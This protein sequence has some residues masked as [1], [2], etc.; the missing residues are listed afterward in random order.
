MARAAFIDR[1]TPRRVSPKVN[2]GGS[3]DGTLRAPPD[4]RTPSRATLRRQINSAKVLAATFIHDSVLV[5]ERVVA[6]AT[7]RAPSRL[8]ETNTAERVRRR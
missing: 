6:D 3:A 5:R 2:E 8:A 7:R 4:E 1:A